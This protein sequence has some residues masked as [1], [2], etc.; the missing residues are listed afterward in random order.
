[1][2][3]IGLSWSL[4]CSVEKTPGSEVVIAHQLALVVA[5][6]PADFEGKAV[7]EEREAGSKIAEELVIG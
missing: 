2:K 3:R 7:V 5:K 1:M 4:S 6:I